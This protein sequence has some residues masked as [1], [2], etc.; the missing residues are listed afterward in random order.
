M[1]RAALDGKD[2]EA[3]LERGYAIVRSEGRIVRDAAT[4]RAGATID[5]QLSRGTVRARVEET[6]RDG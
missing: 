6:Q 1:L 5:A 4:L 3:I 2:P